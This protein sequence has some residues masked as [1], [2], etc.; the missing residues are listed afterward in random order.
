METIYKR[1]VVD[2]IIWYIKTNDIIFLHGARQAGKTSILYYLEKQ[3]KKDG[4]STY[5]ID[6]EDSR[7][8]NMLNAGVAEFIRHLREEGLSSAEQ[9]GKVFVFIDE[10]QHLSDP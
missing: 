5:F 10:I 6:L 1:T 4:K 3:L 9:K 8:V 2:D 7:F